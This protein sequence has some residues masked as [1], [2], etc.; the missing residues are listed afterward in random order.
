VLLQRESVAAL[1]VAVVLIVC[2]VAGVVASQHARDKDAEVL[3][4]EDL[5]V[6][7][8]RFQADVSS[9]VEDSRR[10][11][12]QVES[13]GR[14]VSGLATATSPVVAGVGFSA[15]A[16]ST[17]TVEGLPLAAATLESAKG[18]LD[19]ARDT[20][21][22]RMLPSLPLTGGGV[23]T[24]V[25]TPA[26]RNSATAPSLK[27]TDQRRADLLGYVMVGLDLPL[28]MTRASQLGSSVSV[29]PATTS[30]STATT[31]SAAST[32]LTVAGQG[33]VVSSSTDGDAGLSVAEGALLALALAVAAMT[34]ASG[35]WLGK[36]RLAAETVSASTAARLRLMT[37]LAPLVQEAV[38]LGQ[39]LPEIA[40][41]LREELD[42]AGLAFALPTTK[43]TFRDVYALGSV[44]AAA[45]LSRLADTLEVGESAAITLDRGG[46][47]V[48]VLRVRA[49]RALGVAELDALRG[50]AELATAAIVSSQLFEQQDAALRALRVVDELK[51]AFLSTASHELRTPVAAI[52]GFASLLEDSWE[53]G[54]DEAHKLYAGRILANANALDVLL[55]D[56][57]DFS[58]LERG[59]RLV[60]PTLIDI[61]TITEQVME[62]L[63]VLFADHE[64]ARDLRPTPPVLADREGVERILTNLASNAVRYSPPGTT[65]TVRTAPSANGAELIVD[66]E[67]PGVPAADR[68]KVFARF[69]RGSTDEVI[70]TRGTGIGLAVVKE[71]VDQMGGAVS[72]GRAPTGGARFRVWFASTAPTEENP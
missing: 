17:F 61:T 24:F 54:A 67:G 18:T 65:V 23:Q 51:T 33:W 70:R 8:A 47:T 27:T 16:A 72:V 43:G 32:T 60:S 64:L 25:V 2:A 44:P 53:G 63:S 46:R 56:L 4:S 41:R 9:A 50:A 28:L 10:M 39:I 5:A 6:A 31:S 7:V 3:R 15:P 13:T 40:T 57:L 22:P 45:P 69:F 71:Y 49:S 19:L 55:Q 36:R 38:D 11:A 59:R 62:R 34:W 14:F 37:T 12:G 66:D 52:K 30:S 68:E 21:E 26:F 58:R 35:V 20:A 48:G 42:L 1:L 29:A